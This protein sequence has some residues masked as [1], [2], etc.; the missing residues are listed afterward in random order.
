MS[1]S[2]SQYASVLSSNC[3]NGFHKTLLGRLTQG[4]SALALFPVASNYQE[5]QTLLGAEILGNLSVVAGSNSAGKLLTPVLESIT[6]DVTTPLYMI[7]TTV[8]AGAYGLC[9]AGRAMM[10]FSSF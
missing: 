2:L 6:A 5:N 9:N 4:F 8:D 1:N 10:S 7:G 3:Y